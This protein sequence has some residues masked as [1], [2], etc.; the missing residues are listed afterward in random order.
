MQAHCIYNT[1]M[2]NYIDTSTLTVNNS[3]YNPVNHATPWLRNSFSCH[4]FELRQWCHSFGI[5]NYSPCYI[6]LI[7]LC[8]KIIQLYIYN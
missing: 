4:D 6:D 7:V 1:C 2:Y 8:C 5:I 3:V